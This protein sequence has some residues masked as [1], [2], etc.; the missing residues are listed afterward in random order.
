M[1]PVTVEVAFVEEPK[2]AAEAVEAVAVGGV[3]TT[4][5]GVMGS[6]PVMAAVAAAAVA[7]PGALGA[8]SLSTPV[9]FCSQ[10]ILL[11]SNAVVGE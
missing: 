4:L 1:V 11:S 7:A 6:W 3:V 2:A 10:S 9:K 8:K 5:E